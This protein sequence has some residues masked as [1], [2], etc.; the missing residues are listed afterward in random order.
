MALLL[1]AEALL[2]G[3]VDLFLV[4]T[5]FDTLNAKAAL[6]AL[7]R[8]FEDRQLRL[9]VFVRPPALAQ[10]AVLVC[11]LLEFGQLP[12]L[13]LGGTQDAFGSVP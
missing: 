8:L 3:G 6:Y 2:D 4:E 12:A 9:P 11:T 1:Q 5:I 7:E 10:Q 13:M